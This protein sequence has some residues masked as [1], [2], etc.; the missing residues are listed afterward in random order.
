M[1]AGLALPLPLWRR[2]QGEKALV[3]AAR[4]RA[5]EEGALLERDVSYEVEW[6]FHR[7]VSTYE[8]AKLVETRVAPAAD[9]NVA[10]LTEG[11]RAGK[12]DLFRVIQAS[13]EAG[14]ARRAQLGSVRDFWRAVIALDRATGAI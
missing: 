3:M 1:G 6:A 12:F 8:Q 5:A 7:V 4:A 2:N 10:L 13:R 9:K 11:W 14:E